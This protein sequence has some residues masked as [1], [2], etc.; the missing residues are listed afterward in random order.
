MIAARNPGVLLAQLPPHA[1]HV[2]S[3][4]FPDT[5]AVALSG[6]SA[7]YFNEFYTAGGAIQYR[8]ALISR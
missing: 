7:V 4:V 6:P 5:S 2:E 1:L 8:R 3:D